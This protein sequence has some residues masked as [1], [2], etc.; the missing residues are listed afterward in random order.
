MTAYQKHPLNIL[1]DCNKLDYDRLQGS[2]RSNGFDK[3]F[4]II[5][6]EGMILDGWQ[7]YQICTKNKIE[8]T[9]T[10]FE[11]GR[12]EAIQFIRK[13]NIRRNLSEDQ[14][15]SF[16]VDSNGLLDQY[17]AKAD[18]RS[19]AGK[20]PPTSTTTGL[21]VEVAAKDFGTTGGK[22]K[23]AEK[24]KEESPEEFEKVKSG[25]KKLHEAEKVVAS[26]RKII[27][28]KSDKPKDNSHIY[29]VSKRIATLSGDLQKIL[30]GDHKPTTQLDWGRLST[31]NY[32]L[33]DIVRLAASMGVDVVSIVETFNGTTRITTPK[34]LQIP[35]NM[36]T[37]D[38]EDAEIVE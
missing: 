38:I 33:Y 7:R 12:E 27:K 28:K 21:A 10:E 13:S 11:G 29:S 5:L 17:R 26:S 36:E 25:E 2:L 1:P 3:K 31:I 18:E 8:F 34:H 20:K 15:A 9:T 37:T 35:K 14:I 24:L 32:A 22:I 4:P 6:F 23:R 16:I 30:Q 19:R